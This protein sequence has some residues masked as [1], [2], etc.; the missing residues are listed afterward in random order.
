MYKKAEAMITI[1]G[2][3][4]GSQDVSST[5]RSMLYK[6]SLHPGTHFI[7]KFFLQTYLE[8]DQPD[9]SGNANTPLCM[10]QETAL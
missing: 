5:H 9:K 1:E 7:Q 3:V 10:R 2:S 4:A 8:E 6:S